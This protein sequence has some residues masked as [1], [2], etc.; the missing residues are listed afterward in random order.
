[1]ELCCYLEITFP[2][3]IENAI[4]AKALVPK[5]VEISMEPFA[6]SHLQLHFP[7]ITLPCIDM[8]L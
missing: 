5:P 6:S 2:A 4:L 8:L 7:Q 1:M 3:K